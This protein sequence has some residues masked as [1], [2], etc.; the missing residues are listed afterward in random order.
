MFTS[1]WNYN[2]IILKLCGALV[3][4]LDDTTKDIFNIFT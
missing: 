3:T 4:V 2:V 1:I